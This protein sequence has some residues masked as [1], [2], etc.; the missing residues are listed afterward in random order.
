MR[1]ILSVFLVASILLI[2]GCLG[3]ETPTE[4]EI[5]EP[6]EYENYELDCIDEDYFTVRIYHMDDMAMYFEYTEAI[7]SRANMVEETIAKLSEVNGYEFPVD[8]F[9]FEGARLF[10]NIPA[11]AERTS[12]QGSF[13]G[14]ATTGI[15]VRTFASFPDVETIQILLGGEKWREGVHFNFSV[16]FSVEDNGTIWGNYVGFSPDPVEV[17]PIG[18]P[19]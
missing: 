17:F 11:E 3:V 8:D 4:A 5:Y 15:V 10:V 6:D 16:V 12:L 18:E 7:I 9:W 1:K 2:G 14:R 19:I 13:G